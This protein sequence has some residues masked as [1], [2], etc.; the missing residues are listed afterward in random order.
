MQQNISFNQMNI[1]ERLSVFFKFTDNP[2]IYAIIVQQSC[3]E[4]GHKDASIF[5]KGG[6]KILELQWG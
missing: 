1:S 3:K 5:T 6:S 4:N 2:E